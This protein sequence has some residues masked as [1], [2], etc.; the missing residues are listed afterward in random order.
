MCVLCG[1]NSFVLSQTEK[2]YLVTAYF[3]ASLLD[4]NYA[5]MDSYH[6]QNLPG[7]DHL[8]RANKNNRRRSGGFF[9][10]KFPE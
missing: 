10:S 4:A 7:P 1:H 5:H 8:L 2:R 3:S 9:S 6:N